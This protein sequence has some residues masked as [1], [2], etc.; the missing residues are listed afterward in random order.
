MI[1]GFDFTG[2]RKLSGKLIKKK[3]PVE[4]DVSQVCKIINSNFSD[5]RFISPFKNQIYL[6]NVSFKNSS[7]A[8]IKKERIN[9]KSKLDTVDFTDSIVLGD[10]GE[11]LTISEDGKISNEF[12]Y[13]VD[14][15]FG[16]NHILELKKNEDKEKIREEEIKNKRKEVK[17]KIVEITSLLQNI[18]SLGMDS[19]NIYGTIPINED[20]FLVK[21]DDHF[22]I[23]RDFINAELLR[24][25]N[26][27]LINFENVKVSGID[28]RKSNARINP[29]IVYKKDISNCKFDNYNI[30]PFTD[31][32]KVNIS[33]TDFSECS[34]IS[35]KRLVRR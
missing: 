30:S 34:F 8:I 10:N 1:Q 31:L 2:A 14:K 21:I 13:N 11:K 28:F 32:E 20:L 33:N 9:K 23:N 25:F 27:S 7:G 4:I 3:T 15:L 35:E 6:E 29:Q 26:L 16:I 19:K 17:K 18:E 22:E 12:L 5:V 24:F